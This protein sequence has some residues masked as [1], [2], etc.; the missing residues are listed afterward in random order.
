MGA[1]ELGVD[2]SGLVVGAQNLLE[3]NLLGTLA[4]TLAWT[5][6]QLRELGGD[7][8]ITGAE[9]GLLTE[10]RTA[11]ARLDA[12]SGWRSSPTSLLYRPETADQP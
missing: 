3:P 7:L 12:D 1:V 8:V 5:R 4:R 10:M 2:L 6:I 9:K 11:D